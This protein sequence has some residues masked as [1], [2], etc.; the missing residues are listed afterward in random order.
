MNEVFV[1]GA[2]IGIRKAPAYYEFVRKSERRGKIPMKINV[3]I[4]GT[5]TNGVTKFKELLFEIVEN[6]P[7]SSGFRRRA[8]SKQPP[9]KTGTYRYGGKR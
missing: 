8:F 4:Q 9:R 5:I 3:N 2:P 1:N 6:S 7:A